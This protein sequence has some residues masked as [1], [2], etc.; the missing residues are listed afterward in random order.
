MTTF[1]G[2][3]YFIV[4]DEDYC[5]L[6]PLY[7]GNERIIVKGIFNGNF[8]PPYICITTENN[9]QSKTISENIEA[10]YDQAL[11]II[12]YKW[13][14]YRDNGYD[15]KQKDIDMWDQYFEDK[16]DRGYDTYHINYDIFNKC[17]NI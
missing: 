17:N 6:P 11:N 15:L 13:K 12:L 14:E 4:H 7:K 8:H 16:R 9:G 1:G 2:A 3:E 5:E 10:N